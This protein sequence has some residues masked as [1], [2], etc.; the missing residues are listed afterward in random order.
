MTRLSVQVVKKGEKGEGAHD[1]K[2]RSDN[3]ETTTLVL[4]HDTHT[5]THGMQASG[6]EE[7]TQATFCS[8]L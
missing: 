1:K 3:E 8:Q 6:E 4:W 5:H 7:G 2:T